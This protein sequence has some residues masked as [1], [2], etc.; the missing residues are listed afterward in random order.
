MIHPADIVSGD[1][2][3]SI[4]L[5]EDN[6]LN[7]AATITFAFDAVFAYLSAVRASNMGLMAYIRV[8]LPHI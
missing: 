1:T 2:Y 8:A 4:K 5:F 3:I 6:G 7:V